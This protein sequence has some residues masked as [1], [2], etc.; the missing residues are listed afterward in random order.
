M[1]REVEANETVEDRAAAARLRSEGARSSRH[2]A[3]KFNT[4]NT[5]LSFTISIKHCQ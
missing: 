3:P 4:G 1:E 2:E 5:K